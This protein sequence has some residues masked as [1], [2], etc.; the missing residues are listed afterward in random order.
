MYGARINLEHLK[1]IPAGRPVPALRRRGDGEER[2]DA[3]D[4]PLKGK[5][6]LLARLAPTDSLVEMNRKGQKVYTSV[7]VNPKFADTGKTYLVGLAVT[8]DPGQ[9]RH[10]NALLLRQRAK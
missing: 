1:G 4:G 10:R 6:A 5:L 7:E 3:E 2:R 8:D 9:P